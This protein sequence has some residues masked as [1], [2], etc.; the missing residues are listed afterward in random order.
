M[1]KDRDAPKMSKSQNPT[2]E[3]IPIMKK[4]IYRC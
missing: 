4:R 3:V 2:M 1:K